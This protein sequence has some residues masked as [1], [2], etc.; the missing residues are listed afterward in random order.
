MWGRETERR[1]RFRRWSERDPNLDTHQR[2][3]HADQ[4]R[5]TAHDVDR[6]AAVGDG[7]VCACVCVCVWWW[8][9]G[10]RLRLR[11]QDGKSSVE[12]SEG[13]KKKKRGQTDVE[14]I[15]VGSV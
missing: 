8:L 5:S 6:A 2:Q 4:H 1:T 10:L 7:G 13:K 15:L 9:L 12:A 14:V 11:L 3:K